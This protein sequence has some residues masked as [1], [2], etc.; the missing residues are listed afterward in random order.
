MVNFVAA[1]AANPA[2]FGGQPVRIWTPGV[3]LLSPRRAGEDEGNAAGGGGGASMSAPPPPQTTL[4]GCLPSENGRTEGWSADAMSTGLSSPM[5][6]N[7]NAI[8]AAVNGTNNKKRVTFF[9]ESAPPAARA[10]AKTTSAAASPRKT[11]Q[12]RKIERRPARNPF[13][14]PES[15]ARRKKLFAARAGAKPAPN[16]RLWNFPTKIEEFAKPE[17]EQIC[18]EF[19]RSV[20]DYQME[21]FFSDFWKCVNDDLVKIERSFIEFWKSVYES[22]DFVVDVNSFW[23]QIEGKNR[24]ASPK[25]NL[26]ADFWKM[27]E[28]NQA[29]QILDEAVIAGHFLRMIESA[30]RL[31]RETTPWETPARDMWK[32]ISEEEKRFT[33]EPSSPEAL[34]GEFFQMA[35]DSKKQMKTT[36]DRELQAG[37]F[38]KM[39]EKEMNLG[40]EVFVADS[41][42]NVFRKIKGYQIMASNKDNLAE[43]KMVADFFKMVEI[44]QGKEEASSEI[45]AGDFWKMIKNSKVVT[46]KKTKEAM[47]GDFWKMVEFTENLQ[48]KRDTMRRLSASKR[49]AEEETEAAA[50]GPFISVAP[51]K[52]T[53]PD[54]KEGARRAALLMACTSLEERGYMAIVAESPAEVPKPAGRV[55]T[56]S[57]SSSSLYCVKEEEELAPSAAAPTDAAPRNYFRTA[58]HYDSQ[59][60]GAARAAK[61]P[62]M[63]GSGVALVALRK[64]KTSVKPQQCHRQNLVALERRGSVTR[65]NRIPSVS[66]GSNNDRKCGRKTW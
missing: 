26:A 1:S 14:K 35:E 47:A 66:V 5:A 36:N 58:P 65:R 59:Q 56:T 31:P 46:V 6:R 20:D 44:E 41:F 24:K 54:E 28:N 60:L 51:A 55:R 9:N 42:G 45:F 49:A 61:A 27:V 30:Q 50:G 62:H 16:Q 37:Q 39:I 12:D 64:K 33:E 38:W 21:G 4:P 23:R 25:E 48:R 32:L 22:Q 17:K 53:V 63:T 13:R 18:G 11:L 43:A 10:S 15:E 19:W 34:A 40:K 52:R 2:L 8:M 7:V 57:S 3:P 29:R